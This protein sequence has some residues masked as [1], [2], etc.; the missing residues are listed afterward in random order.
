[1]SVSAAAH[2]ERIEAMQLGITSRQ[3]PIGWPG[4]AICIAIGAGVPVGSMLVAWLAMLTNDL[5]TEIFGIPLLI[6][7]SAIWA[8]SGLTRWNGHD[9][10]PRLPTTS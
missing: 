9:D 6:S 1:M 2:V 4:A 3:S 8:G 10:Q 5:P 7:C